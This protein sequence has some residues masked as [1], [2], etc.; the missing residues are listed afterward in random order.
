MAFYTGVYYFGT[1][2]ADRDY[3]PS[4]KMLTK[5]I[6][7]F[8]D[9][10]H[11]VIENGDSGKEHLHW[12][13]V[14]TVRL[15]NLKNSL[16]KI[17]VDDGVD[18]SNYTLD[19]RPEPNVNWRIGYLEKELNREI[20]FSTVA[21]AT[22]QQCKKDYDA[23]PKRDRGLKQGKSMSKLQYI[24]YLEDNGATDRESIIRMTDALRN[25]GK[26]DFLFFD[27]INMKKVILYITRR[28]DDNNFL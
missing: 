28:Y 2:S 16:S 7:S 12:V 27:K 19:L 26:L 20:L 15:D 22:L 1:I 14:S 17:L 9:L 10:L 23:K 21:E 25:E 8:K 13:G 24:E 6:K 18:V 5:L 4:E 11:I 3:R